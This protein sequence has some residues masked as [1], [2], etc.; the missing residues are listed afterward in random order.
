[1]W[2]QGLILFHFTKTGDITC[3]ERQT[4]RDLMKSYVDIFSTSDRDIGTV[5][6]ENP[7]KQKYRQTPPN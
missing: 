7:F 3:R 1:M 5:D 2:L 4:S 6:K